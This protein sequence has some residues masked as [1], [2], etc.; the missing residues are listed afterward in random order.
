M[1]ITKIFQVLADFNQRKILELLKRRDMSVNKI[2]ENFDITLP[3]LSHHLI[4]LKNA[5]LITN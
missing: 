2:A 3:S 5:N 4:I 1:T